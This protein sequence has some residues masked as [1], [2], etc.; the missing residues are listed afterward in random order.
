MPRSETEYLIVSLL[1]LVVGVLVLTPDGD[2]AAFVVMVVVAVDAV[3]AEKQ[4]TRSHEMF[5]IC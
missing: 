3:D 4:S 5:Y 1:Q 2:T